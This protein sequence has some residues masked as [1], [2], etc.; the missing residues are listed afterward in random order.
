MELIFD[1]NMNAY[2]DYDLRETLKSVG[3]CDCNILFVHSDVMFG[4]LAKGLKR[5]EYLQC[6]Y[7]ALASNNVEHI[8]VPSFTYSFCNNEV[9]D[10]PTMTYEPLVIDDTNVDYL[11]EVGF[12]TEEE[13]YG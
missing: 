7:D 8:V 2:T 5:K 11:I 12:Y 1:A 4:T 13:I 10:V 6:L 9:F 3:A